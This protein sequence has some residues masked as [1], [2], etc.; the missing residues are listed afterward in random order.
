ME[1]IVLTHRQRVKRAVHLGGFAL[2]GLGV[3]G[4]AMLAGAVWLGIRLGP[5]RLCPRPDPSS[6][7]KRGCAGSRGGHH[8]PVEDVVR[9]LAGDARIA[10]FYFL[11]EYL[12]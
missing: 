5:T 12:P 4:G 1:L 11:L 2:V 8:H 6:V 7:L 9:H 3:V 10:R